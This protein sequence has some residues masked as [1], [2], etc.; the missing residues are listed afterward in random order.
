MRSWIKSAA[1]EFGT[2]SLANDIFLEALPY[3][4]TRE[5]GRKITA[6][7]SLYAWLYDGISINNVVEQIMQI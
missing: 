1:L 3:A 2:D 5:Y 7:A 4:E 6:A